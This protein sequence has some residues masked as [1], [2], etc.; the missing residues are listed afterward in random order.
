M[1]GIPAW[2]AT[3]LCLSVP[4]LRKDMG[5]PW[6]CFNYGLHS[7]LFSG[8]SFPQGICFMFA[9]Q[10]GGIVTALRMWKADSLRE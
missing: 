2:A 5:A 6:I 8:L 3:R 4:L 7:Q 10:H 9:G 1:P